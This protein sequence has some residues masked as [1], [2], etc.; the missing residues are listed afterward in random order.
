LIASLETL[1]IKVRSETPTSFFFVVSNVAFLMF[2]LLL[3]KAPALPPLVWA[4]AALSPF[5]RRLIPYAKCKRTINL[6][7]GDLSRL[8]PRADCRMTP[9]PFWRFLVLLFAS[10]RRA[11]ARFPALQSGKSQCSLPVNHECAGKVIASDENLIQRLGLKFANSRCCRLRCCGLS[12]VPSLPW[13]RESD[14]KAPTFLKRQ[15]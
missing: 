4:F 6:C 5:G 15:S 10:S 2:G 11:P 1:L 9:L 7:G 3:P 13:G 8:H 14:I 12:E